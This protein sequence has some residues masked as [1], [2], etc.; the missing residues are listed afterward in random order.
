MKR[1]HMGDPQ[2]PAGVQWPDGAPSGI[3]RKTGEKTKLSIPRAATSS[4]SQDAAV[5]YRPLPALQSIRE[6]IRQ[7]EKEAKGSEAG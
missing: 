2:P 4:G 6:R 5:V 3:R 1:L 7:K